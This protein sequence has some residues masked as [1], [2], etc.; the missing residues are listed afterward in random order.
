MQENGYVHVK[1]L[2]SSGF[3][4]ICLRCFGTVAKSPREDDLT[5]CDASHICNKSLAE[6]AHLVSMPPVSS[7]RQRPRRAS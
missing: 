2:D 3:R 7:V 5:E 6:N 1:E 4:S